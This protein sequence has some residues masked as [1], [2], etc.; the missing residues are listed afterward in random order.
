MKSQFGEKLKQDGLTLHAEVEEALGAG[1]P[2]VALESTVIAH[3]L[4]CPTNLE[5]ARRLEAVVCAE[6]AVPA[7]IAVLGGQLKVGLD[8]AELEHLARGKD[9][10]KVSRRDLP[11]VVA[12]G[13][14]GATTVAATMW[15]AA[16]AGIKVFATGGIGGV[17]RGHPFDVSADLPELART[18]VAVVCAGAKSILDLPLSLEWLETWGVPVIGYATDEFPAF[19]TRTSGLPVDVRADSPQ[20]AAEIIRTKWTLGLDGGLLVVAPV[21]AGAALS[22]EVMEA[23]IASALSAA[24][25]QGIRGKALTPFL[26]TRIAEVTGGDSLKANVALLENNAAI[27]ARIAGAMAAF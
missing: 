15:I 24:D 19:Y 6:G 14:D 3:G 8:D 2:V 11:I 27:A 18:P 22:A 4:P 7:T 17:H 10:R 12:Q 16:R 9:I 20:A 26:L 25:A 5:T 13:G 1:R 21:P 23:A